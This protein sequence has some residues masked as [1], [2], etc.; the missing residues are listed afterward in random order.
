ML[1]SL[2]ETTDPKLRWVNHAGYFLTSGRSRL[3]CDPWV[4]GLAFHHGWSL[5]APCAPNVDLADATHIWF[6]HEHPDRFSPQT[7][8]RRLSTERRAQVQIL[9]QTTNDRKLV[10]FCRGLGFADCVEMDSGQTTEIPDMRLEIG[11][12]QNH[13]DSWLLA[14]T[15]GF[16]VLNMND[17][18]PREADLPSIRDRVGKVDILLTQFSYA[19]W[20]GNPDEPDR[21]KAAAARKLDELRKQVETFDPRWVIPFASFVRFCQQENAFMNAEA[22]TVHRAVEVI[23]ELG[24]T[25]VVLFPGDEWVLGAAHDNTSALDRY[26]AAYVAAAKEPLR[27]FP[28]ISEEALARSA[29]KFARRLLARNDRRKLLGFPPFSAFLTDEDRA[30]EFS[31]ATGLTPSTHQREGCDVALAA[32]TL[33]YCFEQLWGFRT[34]EVSGAYAKPP[35]GDFARLAPY[36]WVATLNN[37]G[38]CVPALW[39]RIL[40]RLGWRG[41]RRLSTK[42]AS[43]K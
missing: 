25:P 19:N 34:L 27:A 38:V 22:N 15:G 29:T 5:L 36:D 12:G 11:K 3:L 41:G 6:S 16:R 7:L 42:P 23:E 2:R 30:V 18:A 28:R 35:R 17:C 26:A 39:V 4:D 8:R 37:R 1:V 14:E 40:N 9:F 31:F 20:V 43:V 10:G 21:H 13:T 24:R 33:Q 32:A